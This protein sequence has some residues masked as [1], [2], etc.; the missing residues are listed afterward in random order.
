[1]QPKLKKWLF[2]LSIFAALLVAIVVLVCVSAFIPDEFETADFR[3]DAERMEFIQQFFDF[4][5]P[6][7]FSDVELSY[8]GGGITDISLEAEFNMNE[9]GYSSLVMILDGLVIDQPEIWW[10]G[11]GSTFQKHR[12]FPDTPTY[13]KESEYPDGNTLS[14]EIVLHE[15]K[16][17]V[18]LS[19]YGI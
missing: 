8:I 2:G 9:K 11:A 6:E 3:S 14:H 15:K 4:E 7:G 12:E 13:L 10:N 19:A 5:I 1:M 16:R 17:R 18:S